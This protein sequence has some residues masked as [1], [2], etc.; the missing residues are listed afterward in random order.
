MLRKMISFDMHYAT[1]NLRCT[2]VNCYQ[3]LKRED[4]REKQ[5]IMN[6]FRP[7]VL[8]VH[9]IIN[10]VFTWF[11]NFKYAMELPFLSQQI[12]KEKDTHDPVMQCYT[13]AT[14]PQ[15]TW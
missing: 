1:C 2:N 4:S 13:I 9:V 12:I 14:Q 7:S 11:I 10:A 15:V 3:P 8:L 6:V 5:M